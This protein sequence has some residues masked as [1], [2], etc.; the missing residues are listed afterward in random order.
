MSVVGL[1]LFF[2]SCSGSKR[3]SDSGSKAETFEEFYDQF[4]ADEKF[5]RS[6][7]R[8]PLEGYIVD[9]AGR[10]KWT[11]KNWAPLKNKVATLDRKKYKVFI[12]KETDRYTEKFELPDSG[13]AAEYRYQ[14][15]GGKWYLVYAMDQN[16]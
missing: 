15:I 6:R 12:K 11:Q 8:F 1:S 4:Y 3:G 10:T 2:A 13:F 16:L 14:L 5:Q 7:L 9:L